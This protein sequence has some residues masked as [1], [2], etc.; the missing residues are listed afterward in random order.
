MVDILPLERGLFPLI[1]GCVEASGIHVGDSSPAFQKEIEDFCDSKV[2]SQPMVENVRAHVRKLLKFASYSA[3]G[4]GKPASE[5]LW[6]AVSTEKKFPFINN[7]VDVN[8][9]VSLYSGFPASIFDLDKCRPPLVIRRGLQDERYIFNSSGQEMHV[10]D[11]LLVADQEG[12][13]GNPVRDS[14]RTKVFQGAEHIL[15]VVYSHQSVCTPELM[16]EI[17]DLFGRLLTSFCGATSFEKRI[18]SAVAS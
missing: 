12:P 9:Y 5:Y 7:I 14:Q 10:R 6:N 18:L 4:R 16:G 15:A 1:A 11:L 13:I 17:V 2:F 3:T 8:N